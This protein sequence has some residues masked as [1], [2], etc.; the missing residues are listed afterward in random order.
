MFAH[1]ENAERLSF[2]EHFSFTT[3]KK[4]AGIDDLCRVHD[5]GYVNKVLEHIPTDQ[6]YELAPGTFLAPDS[7][8][9]LLL[10]AGAGIQ[11]VKAVHEGRLEKAF[12]AVRP[13]GHHAGIEYAG[14]FCVFNNV[15]IAAYAAREL[16]G[17]ARPAIIDFDVHHGNGTQDIVWHDP[18]ICYA[19]LHQAALYPQSGSLGGRDQIGAH[20]QII[21]VPMSSQS[22][23]SDV[24][25]AMIDVVLP[26][27]KEHNPD[28]LFVSAGFDGHKQDILSGWQL[29]TGDY[30]VLMSQLCAFANT[31]CKGR[32]IAML[33]GGYDAQSLADCIKTSMRVMKEYEI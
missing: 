3:I 16:Y 24:H 32:L 22:T 20:N 30:A 15:A 4:K 33:E 14:G 2:L 6:P 5:R 23:G 21:N 11:S 25:K 27:V 28:I 9:M 13:P 29:T 18:D 1:P 26:Q 19:S 17:F 7:G 12:C 31:H 10:A 8:E